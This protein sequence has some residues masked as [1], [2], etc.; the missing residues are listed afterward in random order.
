MHRHN[1]LYGQAQCGCQDCSDVE[2][3]WLKNFDRVIAHGF[4]LSLKERTR[5]ENV[6]QW[7]LREY[8]LS[9][10]HTHYRLPPYPPLPS[11]TTQET[12]I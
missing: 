10:D 8:G 5:T 12:G 1:T 2:K 4:G 9:A 11:P 6:V 3:A 7:F